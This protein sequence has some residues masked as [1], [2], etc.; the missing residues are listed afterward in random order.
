M[1]GKSVPRVH[2]LFSILL[3]SVFGSLP[4][5]GCASNSST[6]DPTSEPT[7]MAFVDPSFRVRQG[8]IKRITVLPTKFTV[9][10]LTAG[11]KL[12]PDEAWS[13]STQNV[14]A[15]A[16]QE[17]LQS[18]VVPE[19]TSLREEDIPVEQK[20]PVEYFQNRMREVDNKLRL[21]FYKNF[22]N[23]AG[24]TAEQHPE[25]GA[26]GYSL[27]P[28][29]KL[30]A[31]EADALLF[32][33]GLDARS[34]GGRKAL[35]GG[36]LLFGA[37]VGAVTGY[38]PVQMLGSVQTTLS[39]ALVDANTGTILWHRQIPNVL[40]AQQ[41]SDIRERDGAREAVKQLFATFPYDERVRD[42]IPEKLAD[43]K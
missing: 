31:G 17:E 8:E 41:F 11:N 6:P 35:Q 25:A 38:M 1:I 20:Q 29:V 3:L 22:R 26:S 40:E 14:V 24:S 2:A 21:N 9:Y 32:V 27:G 19:I 16:F 33:S 12:E 37:A 5:G 30:I 36:L 4:F 42:Q 15:L 10:K 18:R 43:K 39:M 34:T 7:S 28:R 23:A 13:N